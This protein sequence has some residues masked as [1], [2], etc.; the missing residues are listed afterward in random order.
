MP[1]DEFT[2]RALAD[3]RLDEAIRHL[4][5][6]R[7][8]DR[9]PRTLA[10]LLTQRG[11]FAEAETILRQDVDARLDARTVTSDELRQLGNAAWRADHF[12]EA[13]VDLRKAM[14][15][16]AD[17]AKSEAIR[18][19]ITALEDHVRTLRTVDMKLR[20]ADRATIAVGVVLL[21]AILLARWTG[22]LGAGSRGESN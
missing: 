3:G 6:E 2:T 13:L 7:G 18:N 12:E 17:L 8:A 16:E 5:E 21:A 11:R 4:A 15:R 20:S 19:D 10:W 22:R 9:D 1:R 14:G